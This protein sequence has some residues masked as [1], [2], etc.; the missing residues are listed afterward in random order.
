MQPWVDYNNGIYAFDAGY[1]RPILAAIHMV[2]ENGRVAL[3]DT[4]TNDSLPATMNALGRL[5]L[6]PEAV[7]YVMLTHIH[8]DH[9]GGAGAMMSAFPGARLVVHS[10]GAR[11]MA[12]PAKLIAGVTAVYGAEYTQRMYGEILPVPAERIVEPAHGDEIDL[13]GRKILCLDTPGHAR[14]HLCFVD[15]KTGGIFSGDMFGLSYREMDIEGRQFI[16]PTTTPVQFEPDAMH[17]SI[18]LLLSYKPEAIYLTHYSRVT[19]IEPMGA[20]LHRLVK[21][22][23][24]IALAARHAGEQ[25]HQ[26]IKSGVAALLLKE[27]RDFGSQLTDDFLLELWATDVELNAQGLGVWLDA[28]AQGV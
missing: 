20:T 11:H 12:A 2:V 25:R 9:A 6:G 5:G 26:Q 10:R 28:G 7:D 8:L 23:T 18:D 22:H 3:V 19:D 27:A 4:G 14:H 13:G 1:V 17:A 21:A 24:D 15:K 16:F